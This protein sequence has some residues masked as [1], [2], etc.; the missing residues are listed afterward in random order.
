MA[1]ELARKLDLLLFERY[2]D[3]QV[4]A[5]II[6]ETRPDR[7]QWT[8]HFGMTEF[9]R[10]MDAHAHKGHTWESPDYD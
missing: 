2:G 8:E 5:E 7:G 9:G 3:T 10:N 6:D 1:A 4:L